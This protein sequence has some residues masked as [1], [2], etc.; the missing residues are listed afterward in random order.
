LLAFQ[1][2]TGAFQADFGDGPFDDFYSTVQALPAAAGRSFLI[3]GRFISA[4]NGADCLLSLQDT[5]TG[6]W[7]QFPGFGPEAAGT[8]RAMKALAAAG[9]DTA[10]FLPILETESIDYLANSRGGGVGGVLQ[11]VLSA[12]GDVTDFAGTD[13]VLALNNA[14]D[15]NGAYDSIEFGIFAHAK[16]MLGL[17]AAGEPVDPAAVDLLLAGHTNGDFSG[18][19]NTGIALQV[20]GRLAAPLPEAVETLYASQLPDAGWGLAFANPSSTGEVV[21]GL[22]AVGENP[23]SPT[24]SKVISGTLVSSADAIIAGQME[25]GCWPNLYGPGESSFDTVD[26][27]LMLT[28][29]PREMMPVPVLI[30]AGVAEEPAAAT[31]TAE[32]ELIVEPEP[33]EVPPTAVPEPTAAPEEVAA[34]ENPADNTADEVTATVD[35]EEIETTV[36]ET[37]T[38]TEGH[39]AENTGWTNPVVPIILVLLALGLAFGLSYYW[40]KI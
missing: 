18:P 14:L 16:A 1:S 12:G 28:Q 32:P 22:V 36:V 7:E 3:N 15:E 35:A 9:V 26:A 24:W 11:A 17:L 23:F 39:S 13:L 25:S 40:R 37:T 31:E 34:S 4:V 6:G 8:A 2:E 10:P 38:E 20:L 29:K 5:Q 33:T 19:D 21:Q 27:I 30:D